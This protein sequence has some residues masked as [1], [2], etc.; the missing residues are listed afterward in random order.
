LVV[1]VL[2][3]GS[4]LYITRRQ[5]GSPQEASQSLEQTPASATSSQAQEDV[6]A[7]FLNAPATVSQAMNSNQSDIL[8]QM[9]MQPG[10]NRAVLVAQGLPQPQPGTTY[11]FWF[12]TPSQQVPLQTFGVD[13]SGDAKIVLDAPAPVDT[14]TEVMVTVEPS[15]GSI[16][17]S[18]QVVL[19]AKLIA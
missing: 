9:Y 8:A 1:V 3:L 18:T 16:T 10:L 11:Q 2:L 19:S 7:A 4:T 5:I 13:A 15:G 14:Y 12:A 6:I 17:P